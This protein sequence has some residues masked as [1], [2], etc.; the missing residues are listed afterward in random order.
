MGDIWI[1]FTVSI[2]RRDPIS[3]KIRHPYKNDEAV[4]FWTA[5]TR[6]VITEDGDFAFGR[7]GRIIESR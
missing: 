7:C 4:S 1:L 5:G 6:V 3:N 2:F